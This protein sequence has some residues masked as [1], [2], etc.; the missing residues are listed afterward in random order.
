[1]H[2]KLIPAAIAATTLLLP[3]A[4]HAQTSQTYAG[5]GNSSFSGYLGLGSLA[6][7]EDATGNITFT[8]T[9][10]GM[11][12]PTQG[13]NVSVFYIDSVP[14]GLTDTSTL[15]DAGNGDGKAISGYDGTNRSV[16]TFAPG[17]GADYAVAFQDT[18]LDIFS[19]TSGQPTYITGVSK[20]STDPFTFTFP[21]TDIGLTPVQG[22]SIEGALLSG[23]FRSNE[24]IGSLNGFGPS[25]GQVGYAPVTY[26]SFVSFAPVAVAPAPEPNSVVSLLIGAGALGG[27]ILVRR[28]Q[29]A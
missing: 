3:L 24:A 23:A 16:A 21:S 6:V 10:G 26:G 14:G 7:S 8:Q 1:M 19:L 27:A 13:G 11:Y 25:S 15:M 29:T 4:G 12:G 22:F 18:Y 17:F 2:N 9:V 28:R 5:N 20:N